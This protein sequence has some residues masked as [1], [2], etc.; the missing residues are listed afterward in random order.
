MQVPLE[1]LSVGY[2][3]PDFTLPGPDGSPLRFYD[4]FAGRPLLLLLW[5]GPAAPQAAAA[6]Q[7][8][9]AR[10]EDFEALDCDLLAV[11]AT[12]RPEDL[13]DLP[14]PLCLDAEGQVTQVYRQAAGLI[15]APDSLGAV[16]LDANQ[17]VLWRG[18]DGG[19]A[20]GGLAENALAALAAARPAP[21]SGPAAAPQQQAA[22][23]LILPRV[24]DEAFCQALI[25]LWQ[26]G[27]PEEGTVGSAD[28]AGEFH[29][30][31][32]ERKKRL[33][34]KIHDPELHRQLELALGERIAP[35]MEKA[36][37]FANFHFERFLVGCY[38]AT[39][40]DRFRP[41]RDNLSEDT[42]SRRFAVSVNLNEGFEGGGVVFPE[43]GP[44]SYCPGAGGALI[45]SCSLIHEAMPVTKGA[46]YV[47]L[48]M[49]RENSGQKPAN[50]PP[51]RG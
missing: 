34:L 44:D 35:E 29:R 27:N 14:L 20:N 15:G 9:S 32:H 47:L 40:D 21:E 13:P 18:Q 31:Y 39:R 3:A 28:E 24:F 17:R 2:R 10:S 12:G 43:Y 33:D 45:F 46:R 5:P 48:N 36:F 16:L 50:R 38:D 26:E 19:L 37:R 4:S 6:L 22:P 11:A 42:A 25:R 30:V 7:A 1:K 49:C 51:L 23:I 8:L 41:H